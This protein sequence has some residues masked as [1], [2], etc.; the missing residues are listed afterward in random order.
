MTDEKPWSQPPVSDAELD[1]IIARGAVE[2]AKERDPNVRAIMEDSLTDWRAV[3]AKRQRRSK[4]SR[5]AVK[6]ALDWMKP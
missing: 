6:A 1:R 2:I 3:K 5:K 4:P